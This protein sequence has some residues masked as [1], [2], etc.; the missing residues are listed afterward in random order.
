MRTP[1]GLTP[2]VP[3]DHGDL[4]QPINPLHES[5][6]ELCKPGRLGSGFGC[7]LMETCAFCVAV[8]LTMFVQM[9]FLGFVCLPQ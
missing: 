6:L 7:I 3:R 8:L 4:T 2:L 9:L 1:G 5:F